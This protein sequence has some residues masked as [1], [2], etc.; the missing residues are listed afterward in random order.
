MTTL[1]ELERAVHQLLR[2]ERPLGEVAQELGV[3]VRRLGVYRGFIRTHVAKALDKSFEDTRTLFTPAQWVELSDR[4]FA[5]R[6]PSH[7]ELSRTAEPFPAWLAEQSDPWICPFAVAHAR[8]E[9]EQWVAYVHPA[10]VPEPA[11]V[12]AP[13]LNPTLSI[14]ELPLPVVWA[15]RQHD[16]HGEW[17]APLPTPA[18]GAQMVLLFR[19]GGTYRINAWSATDDLLFALKVAYAGLDPSAAAVEAGLDLGAARAA[20]GHAIEIGLVIAPDA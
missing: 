17:P 7:W 2:Q 13:V 8:Y 3:D 1:R 16:E 12:E 4:F 5:E 15:S 14:L 11:A 20:W 18:D 6:P 19:K 10:D 9:W